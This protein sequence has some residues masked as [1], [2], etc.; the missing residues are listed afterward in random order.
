M[1]SIFLDSCVFFNCIEKPTLRNIISHAINLKFSVATSITV[2]GEVIDQMRDHPKCSEYILSFI[3]LLNEWDV[4]IFYPDDPVRII[5][6]RLGDGEDI[7]YRMEKTDGVH[8]GYAMAYGCDYFITGDINL[9]HF[10]TP[11]VI[12]EV[13]FFKPETMALNKFKDFLN[14]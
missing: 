6:F 9:L 10:K 8:L 1:K 13:G 4:N 14:R 7:D 3:S 12:E 11:R 2:V 5:C